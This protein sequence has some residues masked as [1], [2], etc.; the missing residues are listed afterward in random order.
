MLLRL[1]PIV[2]TTRELWV[3]RSALLAAGR[4]AEAKLRALVSTSVSSG[5][6]ADANRDPEDR[7]GGQGND[8]ASDESGA[9]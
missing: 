5:A 3:R 7:G 1:L 6:V 4:E 2:L 9:E 8:D